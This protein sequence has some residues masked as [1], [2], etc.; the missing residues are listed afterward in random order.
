MSG[1][2]IVGVKVALGGYASLLGGLPYH[3]PVSDGCWNPAVPAIGSV[4]GPSN[5]LCDTP[6][7]AIGLL[8]YLKLPLDAGGIVWGLCAIQCSCGTILDALP[9]SGP[10]SLI[11]LVASRLLTPT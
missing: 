10:D 3:L 11:A 1:R 5:G 2:A 4:E 7:P 6:G 8:E 9:V